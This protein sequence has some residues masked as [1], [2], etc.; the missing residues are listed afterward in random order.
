MKKAYKLLDEANE[1]FKEVYDSK[2]RKFKYLPEWNLNKAKYLKSEIELSTRKSHKVYKRGALIFVDFGVNVGNE[3][4]GNHWALVIS[5]KD[6]FK[7]GSLTVIPI[8]SKE[9]R[10]TVQLDKT[11]G[12]PSQAMI[13][14][15]LRQKILHFVGLGF[16]VSEVMEN[17]LGPNSNEANLKRKKFLEQAIK[18]YT[19]TD[20]ELK[21]TR[22][23]IKF[24]TPE[25]VLQQLSNQSD[26]IAQLYAVR[27]SYEKYKKISYAKCMDIT[28][29]SKNRI[30]PVNKFDP[31]G[32]VKASTD[33]MMKIDKKIKEN[34]TY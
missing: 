30:I 25:E 6:S 24:S 7:N 27:D 4:S 3:L 34:F 29:I 23:S 32:K 31:V 10:F 8:T 22:Q 16:I 21:V 20:Q 33:T 28:T 2:N 15:Y 17:L 13:D 19:I 9:N 11:I 18:D 5:K 12:E 1:I 14:N 26:D